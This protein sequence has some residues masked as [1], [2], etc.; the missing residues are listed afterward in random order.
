MMMTSRHSG[1]EQRLL[2]LR[3]ILA[4]NIA[5]LQDDLT[6]LDQFRDAFE[7]LRIFL[8]HAE[9]VL[10]QADPN[11]S[12][13]EIDLRDRLNQLKDLQSQFTNNHV[14]LDSLNIMG[15]KLALGDRDANQ[16]SELNHRW[17]R[18]HSS[19]GERSKSLQANVLVQQDFSSKCDSWM[20]F[21]AQTEQ[22]LAVDIAGNLL[23]LRD[24]QRMC[25]V[26]KIC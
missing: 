17:R 7:V 6:S 20:T 19:C 23:D 10:E 26:K 5:A 13:D 1:L 15:Y 18:L 21:L 2:G 3:Q 16:L 4:Q 22:D 11:K 24:Q 12:S 14:K 25:Q 8:N 9:T